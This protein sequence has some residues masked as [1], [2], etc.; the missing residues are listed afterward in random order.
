VMHLCF[1]RA[2]LCQRRLGIGADGVIL[3]QNAPDADF[4]MRIINSD[5]TEAESC[6]NGLRCL[7][8]FIHDIGLK[9]NSV[10][11]NINNKIVTG[12]IQDDKITIEMG[13]LPKIEKI[14]LE[15]LELYFL[16]T[17][18]PHT[19]VFSPEFEKA[20]FIRSHSHFD[21]A[22]TNVNFVQKSS[23]G[24]Y[25]VRTFERGVE[26]ETLAC[27]TGACAVAAV[28]NQLKISS[29]YYLKFSGGEIEIQIKDGSLFM[30]ATA[31]LVYTGE[32]MDNGVCFNNLDKSLLD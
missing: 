13:K 14:H 5:G 20:P 18:V 8:Q 22:G 16:N 9:L 12:K 30:T 11:I 1:W 6:G 32:L 29:P 24:V 19:V 4:R 31:K 27:G 10:R 17:G 23:S 25:Q 26:A 3:L 21:P 15:N 28:L 2:R 7:V